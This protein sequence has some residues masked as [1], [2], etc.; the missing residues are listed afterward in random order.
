MKKTI[1]FA[2]LISLTT[3]SSVALAQNP[4]TVSASRFF[5]SGDGKIN[6]A[7]RG[8]IFN[9]TYRN[10]DGTYDAAAMKRI[11]TLYGS[12]VGVPGRE[13][14]PRFVEFLDFLQDRLAPGKRITIHSGYRSP[15]YN[16]GLRNK[17]KLAAKASLHQYAMAAD[18]KFD[19]VSSESVWTFV[20]EL[21]YGGAG[22]YH[23][24]LVHLDVG[25]ARSWDETTSGVGT[26]ISDENKLVDLMTDR[27]IY[28]PG[29]P[30]R[31]QFT[32]MTAFPIGVART[33][34]L[35]RIEGGAVKKTIPFETS[36]TADGN[37][38]CPTFTAIDQLAN[39][40][41]TL[42]AD[43]APGRYRVKAGFCDKEWESQPD[44]IET[45]EFEVTQ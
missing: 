28:R 27:D 45:R 23:G 16:T 32:R 14:A 20:K 33:F 6:I 39:A 42:P 34:A 2:M 21:G 19:N 5:V 41:A 7:G 4:A 43:L 8:G 44:A 29:E 37:C 3:L 10:A 26:D 25:P 9:G 38:S 24:G 1:L 35:E 36:L 13:I 11:N 12:Q 30:I 18:V 40:R 31:L 15:T 22:F 17:G